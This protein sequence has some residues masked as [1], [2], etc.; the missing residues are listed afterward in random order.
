MNLAIWKSPFLYSF[1]SS[2]FFCW[3]SF[4]TFIYINKSSVYIQ[5]L[6]LSL[7]VPK[8]LEFILMS[9]FSIL[10]VPVAFCAL[11]KNSFTNLRCEQFLVF[12]RKCIVL[13]F[14][15]SLEI[16][17]LSTVWF[18]FCLG[19]WFFFCFCMCIPSCPC[20]IYWKDCPFPIAVQ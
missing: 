12:S 13:S 2:P 19:V 5:Y 18:V 8:C 11:F 20:T 14:I 17:F 4:F 15:L 9:Y 1:G 7:F 3:F 10:C 16:H 6:S